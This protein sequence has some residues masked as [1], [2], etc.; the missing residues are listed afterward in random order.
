MRAGS[1]DSSEGKQAWTELIE[2][3]WYPLYAFCRQLGNSHDDALDLTQGFFADLLGRQALD[4]VAES[5]GRFRTF[6]L[7]AFKNYMVNQHR[8]DQA[9]KRGGAIRIHSLSNS[10]VAARFAQETSTSETPEQV[11]DR[12]WV[13]SLLSNVLNRL[14]REYEAAEKRALYEQLRPHLIMELQTQ[15]YADIAR[16]L[17]IS[18]AAVAMSI[19]RMRRRYGE[20]LHEEV[21]A[22]VDDPRDVEDEL[23]HLMAIVSRPS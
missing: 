17:L 20:L 23:R 3:Y 12:R 5:K 19:H 10:D 14:R 4:S 16:K 2:C 1:L 13:E 15:S 18:P 11:F 6:L 21:A 8:A 7:T 9:L 22:T